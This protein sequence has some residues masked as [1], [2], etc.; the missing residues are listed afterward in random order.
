[1]SLVPYL[2]IDK[3][4]N[5]RLKNNDKYFTQIQVSMYVIGATKCHFYVYSQCD[6]V[7]LKI[8]RDEEF[9]GVLISKI[10]WFFFQN[11]IDHF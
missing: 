7:H 2:L 6:Q 1:M 3:C 5:I 4:G 8:I 11:F 10:E 9:L